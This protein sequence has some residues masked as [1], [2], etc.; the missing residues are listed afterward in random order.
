MNGNRLRPPPI[1]RFSSSVGEFSLDGAAEALMREPQSGQHG[2][3]Q[4]TLFRHGPATVALYCFE[5]GAKLPDHVVDGPLIIHVLE[6]RLTVSTDCEEHDLR[7]GT[8]FRL[9]PCIRHDVHA[10]EASRMLLII[11]LEG[12]Q[13]HVVERS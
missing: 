13:S 10:Q 5:A 8:L 2:H 11:C 7:A 6:G 12:P 4:I 3:R 1:L 9:A